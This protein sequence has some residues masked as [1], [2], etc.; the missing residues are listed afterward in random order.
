LNT[1]IATNARTMKW[2]MSTTSRRKKIPATAH[3]L[4]GLAGFSTWTATGYSG[5]VSNGGYMSVNPMIHP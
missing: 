2:G 5:S 3:P 1:A 4:E